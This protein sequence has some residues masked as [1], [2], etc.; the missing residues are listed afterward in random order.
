MLVRI[1]LCFEMWSTLI[2]S[3]PVHL[4][5]ANELVIAAICVLM[6]RFAAVV[7][8]LLTAGVASLLPG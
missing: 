6:T 1:D 8:A 4:W 2:A 7:F 3:V 5:L